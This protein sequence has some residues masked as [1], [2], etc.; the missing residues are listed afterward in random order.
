VI[1]RL[2]KVRAFPCG[3][4]WRGI[5]SVVIVTCSIQ[6]LKTVST[7]LM[8]DYVQ[9]VSPSLGLWISSYYAKPPYTCGHLLRRTVAAIE[10]TVLRAAPLAGSATT[11][12]AFV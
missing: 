4:A 6:L 9:P 12:A 11:L 3:F 2:H 7:Y 8:R 10:V 5:C 1:R